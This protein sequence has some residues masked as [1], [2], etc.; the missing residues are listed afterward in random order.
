MLFLLFDHADI[1]GFLA[2][3]KYPK[4]IM[5]EENHLQNS[6]TH[7]RGCASKPAPCARC[8][9]LDYNPLSFVVVHFF[10]FRTHLLVCV[11]CMIKFHLYN[12]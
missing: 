12:N 3:E 1:K 2:R 4:G 9:E 6:L 5:D 7:N 10:E 11:P 8:G